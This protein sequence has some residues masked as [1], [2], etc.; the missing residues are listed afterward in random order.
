LVLPDGLV[1]LC[2]GSVLCEGS[3]LSL[4]NGSNGSKI[5]ISN[6]SH[7]MLK[8]PQ[9]AT[10]TIR[11]VQFELEQPQLDEGFELTAHLI[12]IILDNTSYPNDEQ[13]MLTTRTIVFEDCAFIQD[14][15]IFSANQEQKDQYACQTAIQ[16]T[17]TTPSTQLQVLFK[18]CVFIG[19]HH[20]I[21][22]NGTPHS[23]LIDIQDSLLKKQQYE[24]IML[25]DPAALILKQT[26]FKKSC[27]QDIKKACINI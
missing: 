5:L 6:K 2:E 10:L 24:S 20:A 25:F 3:E 13:E 16:V 27:Q 21:T 8:N 12:Q 1:I 22:V 14:I 17:N 15:S 7:L 9:A 26:L 4:L 19:Y 11:A 23:V 18:N